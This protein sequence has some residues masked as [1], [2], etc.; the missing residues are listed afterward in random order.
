MFQ[1]NQFQGVP[2]NPLTSTMSAV[3]WIIS[4]RQYS[5]QVKRP[6]R[7][8]F[9]GGMIDVADSAVAKMAEQNNPMGIRSL[10]SS[11]VWLSSMFPDAQGHTID[12]RP[13]A[14]KWT[15]MLMVNNDKSGPGG[16]IRMMSDNQHLYYGFFVEEPC[17]INMHMGRQSFNHNA[18]MII[19]HKTLINK[20]SMLSGWGQK[21]QYDVMS[22]VDIIHPMLMGSLTTMPTTLLRPED[23][24]LNITDDP[25]PVVMQSTSALLE[26][27]Q[28]PLMVTA[29][30][31]VPRSNLEKILGA[32]AGARGSINADIHSGT[33][34]SLALGRDSFRQI[35][36]TNLLDN[37]R[38]NEMGLSAGSSITLG[39]VIQRYNPKIETARQDYNPR[40]DPI[41]QSTTSA[42]NIFA[43]MLT[44]TVPA[45]MMEFKLIEISFHY[46]SYTGAFQLF[47][48]TP[49]ATI[50]V[51]SDAERQGC[52]NGFIYRLTAEILP[53]LKMNH[54]DFHLNM[55]C[56]SGGVTH[57][58]LNFFDDAISSNE[59]FEVPT[60]F[61]GLNSS[62]LGGAPTFDNNAREIHG[63]ISGLVETHTDRQPPL[64]F[65]NE[66]RFSHALN[67]YD[68]GLPDTT[69][70]VVIPS[71]NRWQV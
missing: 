17:N 47:E 15:F 65:Y 28:D 27:Q 34:N 29:N 33:S 35:V 67:L 5:Q 2:T 69:L 12:M 14:P 22:D 43:S 18:M 70:P 23:L 54:G 39:G 59:V 13:L 30:L 11:P 19:T 31:S 7:Y 36:E 49:P 68:Q 48:E 56:S 1:N 52:V 25:E 53:I 37:C 66:D 3:L 9:N 24:Y 20:T 38:T 50:V 44:T 61:G 8:N 4:P 62:L 41:D 16:Q 64:G 32:V 6:L 40:Y 60:I 55:N 63:L 10:I 71:S 58:N 26:Q 21:S 45:L 42:R 46:D 51:M 57:I